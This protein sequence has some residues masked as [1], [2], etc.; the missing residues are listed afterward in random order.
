MRSLSRILCTLAATAV[1]LAA[2]AQQPLPK[3]KFVLEWRYE[4]QLAWFMHAKNKGYYER[5]GLDVTVDSG[6]GSGAAI[7]RLVSGAHDMAS[8]DMSSLIE[9]M[10]NNPGP[11]RLQAVYLMYNE[12]PSVIF[13]LKKNGIASPKDLVGKKISAPSFDATRRQFPI[14]AAAVGIDP[15][16]VTFLSVD[17]ALRETML[18]RG[19]A[20]AATGYNLNRHTYGALGV[21]DEELVAFK[22]TDYKVKLYGSSILAS[23]RFI[24]ENPK[25]VAAF[26]RATNRALIDTIANPAEA[27]KAVKAFD[28]VINERLELEKLKDILTTIDTPFSRANGLGAISKLDLENQVDAVSAAYGIKNKPNADLIFNS[29]FLPPRA[30]RQPNR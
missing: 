13:T 3:V 30:E 15:K 28:P 6:T 26:V 1:A 11:T 29:S 8:G 24:N 17:P 25:A 27:V 12:S 2:H 21:K 19:Q 7:N 5:E 4:G 10:G 23:T 20:D 14:F 18:A 9:Y 16:A 22:F